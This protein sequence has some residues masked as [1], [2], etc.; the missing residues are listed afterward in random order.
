MGEKALNKAR[1][2]ITDS[3]EE[4]AQ[5]LKD[6]EAENELKEGDERGKGSKDGKRRER[7]RRESEDGTEKRSDSKPSKRSS[8]KSKATNALED[9]RL[10]ERAQEKELEALMV[11]IEAKR[12]ELEKTREV[13][14]IHAERVDRAS[15]KSRSTSRRSDPEEEE[16]EREQRK[17]KERQPQKRGGKGK[18]KGE[19]NE[20]EEQNDTPIGA[21]TPPK[22]NRTRNWVN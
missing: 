1:E 11:A 3:D 8:T 20:E 4:V 5:R 2:A 7:T 10:K 6:A 22:K 13:A 12:K 21:R 18:N 9:T 14:A 19:E 15:G 17:N 16:E